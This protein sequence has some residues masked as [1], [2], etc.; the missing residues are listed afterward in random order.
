[1]STSRA[2]SKPRRLRRETV[3]GPGGAAHRVVPPG[4]ALK[5]L[6]VGPNLYL[7]QTLPGLEAVAWTEIAARYGGADASPRLATPQRARAR[8]LGDTKPS[9]FA[10]PIRMRELARRTVPDRASMTIFTAPHP[11]ALK[12]LRTTEDIFAVVGYR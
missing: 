6:R 10:R 7:A 9:E 2:P 8:T 12:L 1:M 11:N 5:P 3:P 4:P